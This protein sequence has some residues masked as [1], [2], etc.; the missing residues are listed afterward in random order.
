MSKQ[1]EFELRTIN[2]RSSEIVFGFRPTSRSIKPVHLANV[3][4]S[5]CLG[6]ARNI[7]KD[8]LHLLARPSDISMEEL[9]EDIVSLFETERELTAEKLARVRRQMRNVVNNDDTVYKNP[10]I[11]GPTF[12]SDYLVTDPQIMGGEMTRSTGRFVYELI[13]HTNGQLEEKIVRQLR[14]HHDGISLLVRPLIENTDSELQE[15]EY[16]SWDGP[17]IGGDPFERGHISPTLVEGFQTLGKHIKESKG[18]INNFPRDLERIVRFGCF[19][20]Y[21]YMVNRNQELGDADKGSRVPI[22]FNY[23]ERESPVG[24]ASISCVNNA[25]SEVENASRRGITEYLNRSGLRAHE[26]GWITERLDDMRL[27]D[28]HREERGDK[29]ERDYKTL[30]TLYDATPEDSMFESFATAINNAIHL[31]QFQ[32]Y[33]PRN[34]VQTFGWRSGIVRPGKGAKNRWYEPDPEIIET[35]VMSVI[36]PNDAGMSLGDFLAELR[37]RY[38]II[39]GGSGQD[40]ELLE[41]WGIQIGTSTEATDLL[42]GSNKEEFEQHLVNL[43]FAQEYADGVTIVSIRN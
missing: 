1:Y 42:S 39:V 20:F 18:K 30:R 28:V 23:L 22:L 13:R 29:L 7:D 37:E 33:P 40:R 25:H 11:T 5:R 26:D 6:E 24:Q 32:A 17:E 34:T 19:S 4:A 9:D 21:L 12:T 35:L 31:S 41:K 15:V 27:I 38:G 14:D 43:G 16:S 10:K 36:G 2:N 3:V 8:V